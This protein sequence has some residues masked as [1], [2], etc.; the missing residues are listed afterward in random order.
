MNKTFAPLPLGSVK[1]LGWLKNQLRIQADGLSG[2]LD[3]FWP[4]VA[5][6]KWIGGEAEGWERGPYWLDGVVPLA[7]LLDDARLKDK[8]ARWLDYILAHQHEDGWFGPKEDQH[9]GSGERELDPWPQFILFK[10]MTQWHE[11][12]G[13]ERIV[14]AMLRALRRIEALLTE[15]PLQ[16]WAK[17]R[18]PDLVI[19]IHWLHERTGEGWLLDLMRMAQAQGY[20]WDAHFADFHYTKKQPQWT[21]ENHVVNHAMALKEPAVRQGSRSGEADG[22]EA[23]ARWMGILDT[24]HGQATG[25]F[26]GDESLAGKN[27]SQGTELCAVVEYMFSLETLLAAFGEA[28]FGDRL[29]RIAYNA[30]PATFTPDMW[31]HQYDQQ[32]NQVICKIAPDGERIYTNNSEDANLFGL[33]P[34]FG[35]CTANMHQGWPKFV[36]SLWMTAPNGGLAA[37][38]YGPSVVQATVAG[39]VAVTITQE[40]EYP[41]RDSIHLTIRAEQPVR[42]PLHLRVPGWATGAS[43]KYG[44]QME[45]LLPGTFHTVERVWNPG[46]T[47]TLRFPMDRIRLKRRYNDAV[48]VL[49][50]PLVFSLKIGEEFRYLR[51]EEPHA[52]WEVYPT[53]PWNYGLALDN[54]PP[55]EQFAVREAP[56]GAVPFAPDAAPVTL[57]VAAR[58]VPQWTLENNAAAPPPRPAS[59]REPV[60]QIELIPYGSS[61]LRVTEFPERAGG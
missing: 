52:D 50:G 51:G 61:H 36:A 19:S 31:A 59:A 32:A 4:D 11:A 25:I 44:E 6:S 8:I 7:V 41:F 46:D 1:P 17:M 40:T 15:K 10:A 60:E 37:V 35:C 43:V 57:T 42:F 28:A 12:T 47:V 14:P 9:V 27:P 45:T 29:E 30:L 54:R 3:E 21:L 2:H 13:D 49:R 34:C 53:T 26:T 18:W 5:R 39:G 16:S 55:D 56:V 48:S 38:A 23:A 33:E 22:R 20:D 58:R 24:Y